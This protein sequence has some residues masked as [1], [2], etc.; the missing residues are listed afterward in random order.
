MFGLLLLLPVRAPAQDT[1]I[2]EIDRAFER[3]YNFDFPGAHA[4]LNN[5]IAAHPDEALPYAVRSSVYLFYELDRLGVLESQFLTSD[6]RIME[7]KGLGPDPGIRAAFQRAV[8]A[9][10]T[11]GNR[12]LASQPENPDALL[13]LCISYGVVS[14]YTALI[15]KRQF[16]SMATAKTANAYAQR[17]LRLNPP[18]YDAYVSTGVSEY[19]LGSM[20]FFLRWFIKFDN[21]KGSKQEALKNLE[22]VSREG[23]YLRP[24]AKVLLSI[25][26]L[27]EK[28]RD[29]A[30]AVLAELGQE[31]PANPLFRRELARLASRTR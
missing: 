11:R 12:I 28:K 2:P 25:I 27:R 5:Y 9:T 13:A 4:I 6:D 18:R 16:G 29:R 1:F 15:E 10:E 17:L 24:F 22:L 26:Y 8:S 19:L 31:F 20:P 23:H 3:L 30:T 14:D 21:I 7:K